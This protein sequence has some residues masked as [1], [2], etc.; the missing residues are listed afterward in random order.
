[1]AKEFSYNREQVDKLDYDTVIQMMWL[2]DKYRK[3]HAQVNKK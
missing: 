1:M 3:I 2:E